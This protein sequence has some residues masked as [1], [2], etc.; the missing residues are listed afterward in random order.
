MTVSEDVNGE[1]KP[2]P[3]KRAP[4]AR[5]NPALTLVT[6]GQAAEVHRGQMRFAERFARTYKG[7]FIHTPGRGWFEWTG[8]YWK[9]CES[10]ARPVAGIVRLLKDA[11]RELADLDK[12]S[13]DDLYDDIRKCETGSAVKGILDLAKS[14]PGVAKLDS[15]LDNRPDLFV[16][17]NGTLDLLTDEFRASDPA[18]LMTKVAGCNYDPDAQCPVYDA[19]MQVWQPDDEM[20]AYIHRIGGSALQGRSTEQTLPVWYGNGANGKGSTLNDGWHTVFGDYA[21]VLAVQVLLSNPGGSDYLP[22]KAALQ[23]ARLIITSEPDAGVRFSAG[24]MKLLTGGDPIDACAKYKAPFKVMP[25]WQIVMMANTRPEPP[26][27]DSAVWRRLRQVNW[28]VDVPEEQQDPTLAQKLQ[29][30]ASGILNRLLEGWRDYRDNGRIRTPDSVKQATQKWR[31]EVDNLG[32]F[33][34]ECV[35]VTDVPNQRVSSTVLFARYTRWCK[36]S[37]VEAGS[38][39]KFAEDMKKRGFEKGPI[40]GT[41]YWK[42]IVLAAEE[43]EDSGW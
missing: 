10:D 19:A 5:K 26:A 36:E 25:T 4:R 20:R 34:S 37:L 40:R 33:L 2:A 1:T 21:K 9:E 42:G 41:I 8:A 6:N 11:L 14:W 28:P 12:A 16:T 17:R 29:A 23:G 35:R 24:T 3:V 15:E 27:D 30:E 7:K 43:S 39:P 32:R 18:D 13:R 38:L 31:T 22:Q